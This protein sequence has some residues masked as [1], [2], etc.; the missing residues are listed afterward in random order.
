MWE[1]SPILSVSSGSDQLFWTRRLLA[2]G[3]KG[4]PRIATVLKHGSVWIWVP[5]DD[6]SHEHRVEFPS[7]EDGWDETHTRVVIIFRW[8]K[9]VREYDPKTHRNKSGK[10]TV[11]V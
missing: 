11:K 8:V 4:A 6:L 3:H 1:D 10:A 9:L 2:N 5:S 7:R